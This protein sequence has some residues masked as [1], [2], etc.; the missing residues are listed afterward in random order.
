[1]IIPNKAKMLQRLCKECLATGGT[2]Y[3]TQTFENEGFVG[4]VVKFVKPW[5]RYLTSIDFG[6]VTFWPEFEET[7]RMAEVKVCRKETMYKS[8]FRQH[9]MVVAVP[10]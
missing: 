8:L 10:K 7:L 5:L 4:R 9:C 6:D 2:V 3:F 1:M